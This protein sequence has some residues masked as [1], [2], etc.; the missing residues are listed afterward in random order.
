[1]DSDDDT[2]DDDEEIDMIDNISL[3][4]LDEQDFSDSA[5]KIESIKLDFFL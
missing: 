1:M 4:C 2:S 5:E 3:V